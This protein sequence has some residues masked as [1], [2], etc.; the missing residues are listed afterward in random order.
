MADDETVRNE[1]EGFPNSDAAFDLTGGSPEPELRELIGDMSPDEFRRFGHQAVDWLA[2]Y[3]EH[4]ERYPVQPDVTPG[5][6]VDALPRSAPDQ[7]EPMDRILAD[8]E[9]QIV[10]HV[11]HWNHPGFMGYFATSGSMPG[12]LGA[13][14]RSASSGRS[15]RHRRRVS[16][17]SRRWP[18]SLKVTHSGSTWMRRMRARRASCR[19]RGTI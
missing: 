2:D 19:R 13:F 18:T 1:S 16:T 10:P 5:A 12:V 3:F 6:L 15:G 8:F 17:R 4:P 11:T 9:R 7:G 14:S